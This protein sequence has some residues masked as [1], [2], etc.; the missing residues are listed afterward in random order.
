MKKVIATLLLGMT[1]TTSAM[2]Q[3][4]HW[5]NQ[6]YHHHR[7]NNYWAPLIGGAIVG[8]LVYDAWNRPVYTPPPVVYQNPPVY[9]PPSMSAPPQYIQQPS[10]YECTE[11]W[12][13]SSI[14]GNEHLVRRCV[15]RY[16]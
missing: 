5:H 9:A 4:R 7:H 8:A 16:E 2:A 15:P 1:L 13:P 10:Y 6:G 3:H 14:P 11:V 12:R